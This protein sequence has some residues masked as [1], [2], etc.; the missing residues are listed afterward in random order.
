MEINLPSSVIE[1]ADSA[2]G[3]CFWALDGSFPKSMKYTETSFEHVPFYL[4]MLAGKPCPSEDIGKNNI[5]ITEAF[6]K[7]DKEN[8][9]K[10][11]SDVLEYY[12]TGVI[13]EGTFCYAR[14][15]SPP[16]K[17]EGAI[18]PDIDSLDFASLELIEN[19]WNGTERVNI[20]IVIPCE[21]GYDL[22]L[23]YRLY[24]RWD[25]LYWE[26]VRWRIE[27]ISFIP[28]KAEESADLAIG[29]WFIE[30]EIEP[31]ND[32]EPRDLYKGIT[33]THRDGRSIFESR[34]DSYMPYE[35]HISPDGNS[36]IVE[37]LTGGG[38]CFFIEDLTGKL[39]DTCWSYEA[40][41]VP[42]FEKGDGKYLA[43]SA[44]WNTDP[45]TMGTYPV[46]GKNEK[47]EFLMNYSTGTILR[48]DMYIYYDLLYVTEGH[49][50]EWGF[51]QET[52]DG[53]DKFVTLCDR[54]YW[55]ADG[56]EGGKLLNENYSTT[57]FGIIYKTP[58]T[59][60]MGMYDE[61]RT[62]DADNWRAEYTG[63]AIK[64]SEDFEMKVE[65]AF[66]VVPEKVDASTF[67]L[68]KGDGKYI[69]EYS[70]IETVQMLVS[71]FRKSY[72]VEV[73]TPDNYIIPMFF[74]SYSDGDSVD[75]FDVVIRPIIESVKL[76]VSLPI[77][78]L[79]AEK[80]ADGQFLKVKFIDG[81]STLEGTLPIEGF[82]D[83]ELLSEEDKIVM[84]HETVLGFLNCYGYTVLKLEG[85]YY[86][87]FNGD[88]T[89]KY[90]FIFK[91]GIFESLN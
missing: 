21:G 37:Y 43:H 38:W 74:Y 47:G 86:L 62:G 16:Q 71:T 49:E 23:G 19:S 27:E 30:F 9:T 50:S 3:G 87:S 88:F 2:F 39:Y 59:W 91:N 36:F 14:L 67:K 17:P 57:T 81:D 78:E 4:S 84:H 46:R 53:S 60:Y 22:M 83:M 29:D 79:S 58:S 26:D 20:S 5:S 41:C 18:I 73:R 12:K 35:F 42:W 34:F 45:E 25:C 11:F 7:S 70:V 6:K 32:Y 13:P 69:K 77:D 28:T 54:I 72:Y 1:I 51:V 90:N 65:N 63:R 85:D 44:T 68:V 33:F 61:Y 56:V 15:L 80:T 31:A 82:A 66:M 48:D 55:T 76:C 40:P 52:R 8:I 75:Y 24:D 89:G 64:V 10:Q